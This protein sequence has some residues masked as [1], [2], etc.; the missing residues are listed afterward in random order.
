MVPVVPSAEALLARLTDS[1]P[2]SF[3][4]AIDQ[5]VL[6]VVCAW[7]QTVQTEGSPNAATSHSMCP[8][9]SARLEAQYLAGKRAA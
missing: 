2:P 3:W 8:A 7:C 4:A 9:C 5:V 6:R 1:Q